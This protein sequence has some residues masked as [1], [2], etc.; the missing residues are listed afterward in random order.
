[1][2]IVANYSYLLYFKIIL[3]IWNYDDACCIHSAIRHTCVHV[4]LCTNKKPNA[5]TIEPMQTL[6][7]QQKCVL[8][9]QLLVSAAN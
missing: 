6:K 4:H 8:Y 5:C 3:V 9:M 1:M 2:Y 7:L